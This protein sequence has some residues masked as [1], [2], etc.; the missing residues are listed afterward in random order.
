MIATL[1][2]QWV[3]HAHEAWVDYNRDAVTFS[4]ME[5]ELLRHLL[6][7]NAGVPR[8]IAHDMVGLSKREMT[9]FMAKVA[10]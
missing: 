2:S 6:A 3:P 1:I 4:R 8:H 9:E 7:S 10:A 5:I